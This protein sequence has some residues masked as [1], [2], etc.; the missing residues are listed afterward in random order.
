M[1]NEE[2]VARLMAVKAGLIS[3][4]GSKGWPYLKQISNKIVERA[5][6]DALDAPESEKGKEFFMKARIGREIFKEFFTTIDAAMNLEEQPW[7]AQL[8]DEDMK[9]ANGEQEEE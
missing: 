1:S 7:F 4:V 9:S 6:T 5:L 8:A 3:T 2:E